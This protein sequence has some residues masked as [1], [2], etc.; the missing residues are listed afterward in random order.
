MALKRSKI[1]MCSLMLALGSAYACGGDD[2]GGDGNGGGNNGGGN[3][4]GAGGSKTFYVANSVNVSQRIPGIKVRFFNPEDGTFY[5]GEYTANGNGEFTAER[6]E[7][8][9]IFV[10]ASPDG[11]W[12]DGWNHPPSRKGEEALVRISGAASASAVPMLAD[13]ENN[14]DASPVAGAVYWRNAQGE[15]EF[16]GCV[17]IDEVEGSTENVRY[18]DD[19]LPT[20]LDVRGADQGTKPYDGVN[21]APAGKFFIANTFAGEQTITARINNEVVATRKIFIVPRK[22]GNEVATEPKQKSN[23]HFAAIW[24]DDPKYTSNPTPADC[25]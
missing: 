2:G 22:E 16:V 17:T 23:V 12:S 1:A 15:D 8:S 11:Q 24:I 10:E 20:S 19:V 14:P 7:G 25:K 4:G 21:S 5:P 9:G 13:Y 6:P 18:F 3:D